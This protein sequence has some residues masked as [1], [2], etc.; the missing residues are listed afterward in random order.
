MRVH[1]SREHRLARQV[2]HA[3][4]LARPR[5]RLLVVTEKD[6]AIAGDDDRSCRRLVR[7]EC[8]HDAVEKNEIGGGGLASAA[9]R[10][11]R[12]R[13]YDDD[14]EASF[15]IGYIDREP[16]SRS[17]RMRASVRQYKSLSPFFQMSSTRWYADTALVTSP[18]FS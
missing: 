7:G 10:R 4:A 13:K 5:A 6:H 11:R 9:R 2:D 12:E 15:Q 8:V 14:A 3:R 1:Q 18:F 16:A 17:S